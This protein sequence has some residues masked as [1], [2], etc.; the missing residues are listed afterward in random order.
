MYV[1]LYSIGLY[2]VPTQ[3]IYQ[4]IYI[5]TYIDTNKAQNMR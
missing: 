5:H 4:Y 3:T 1:N 2:S